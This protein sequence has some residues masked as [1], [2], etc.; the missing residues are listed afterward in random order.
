MVTPASA[1]ALT[2]AGADPPIGI[3]SVHA[4]KLEKLCDRKVLSVL[5][6]WD[7]RTNGTDLDVSWQPAITFGDGAPPRG[8][9]ARV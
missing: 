2:P 9:L 7:F 3:I 5:S 4:F 8:A 6:Q 1:L